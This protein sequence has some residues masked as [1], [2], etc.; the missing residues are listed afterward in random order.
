LPQHWQICPDVDPGKRLSNLQPELAA[1]QT[2]MPK[3]HASLLSRVRE[4]FIAEDG[5]EVIRVLN[6]A[7]DDQMPWTHCKAPQ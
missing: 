4:V 7:I 2:L 3:T 6:K 1:L 5:S